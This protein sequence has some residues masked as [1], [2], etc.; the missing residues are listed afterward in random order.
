MQES[1]PQRQQ[2]QQRKQNT[3]SRVLP[4]KVNNPCRP[5]SAI[6]FLVTINNF[7]YIYNIT[8]YRFWWRQS[9]SQEFNTNTHTRIYH[10]G[11]IPVIRNCGLSSALPSHYPYISRIIEPGCDGN[12]P[13]SNNVGDYCKPTNARLLY[14]GLLSS[15]HG[16]PCGLPCNPLQFTSSAA[17]LLSIC[18][19]EH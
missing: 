19:A 3:L 12:V 8:N 10:L 16:L 15:D 17:Q 1:P 9:K 13:C 6:E 5:A 14:L 7:K 4:W 18:L 11:I 2:Q